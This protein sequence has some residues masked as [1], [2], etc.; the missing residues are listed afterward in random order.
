MEPQESRKMWFKTTAKHSWLYRMSRKMSFISFFSNLDNE[1]NRNIGGYFFAVFLQF[2]TGHS[3][4]IKLKH[5]AMACM[6]F[7]NMTQSIVY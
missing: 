1:T 5:K 4:L 2:L 3:T 6:T 7:F